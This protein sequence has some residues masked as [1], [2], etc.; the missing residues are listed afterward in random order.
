[1]RVFSIT[2]KKI[3]I[4]LLYPITITPFSLQRNVKT[5]HF[6]LFTS[7]RGM[8]RTGGAKVP[9]VSKWYVMPPK[10]KRKNDIKIF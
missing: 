5:V 9:L 4:Y 10:V 8:T 1:M 3:E 6:P 7:I 2:A